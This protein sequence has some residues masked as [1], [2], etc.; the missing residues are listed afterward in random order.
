MN[1]ANCHEFNI[2]LTPL[3]TNSLLSQYGTLSFYDKNLNLPTSE[4]MIFLALND[5]KDGKYEL[6]IYKNKS[7]DRYIPHKSD[8][9]KFHEDNDEYA[10]FLF[11]G[12]FD[13]LF[14]I[15]NLSKNHKEYRE[16]PWRK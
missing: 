5:D 16:R 10:T 15:S 2:E 11:D 8:R 7:T 6:R 14:F 12:L 1:I 13:T 3:V 9:I 4:L